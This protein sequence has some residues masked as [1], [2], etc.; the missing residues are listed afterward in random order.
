MK[1]E[2]LREGNIVQYNGKIARLGKDFLQNI[3]LNSVRPVVITE[4]L[5]PYIGGVEWNYYPT[6]KFDVFSALIEGIAIRVI[7][8]KGNDLTSINIYK[9][10]SKIKWAA[11]SKEIPLHF[12]Q[13]KYFD[14][15]G[16]KLKI[17]L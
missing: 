8:D 12:F 2:E 17:N 11:K 7:I 4:K 13:N 14:Y 1:I 3:S 6:N 5:L 16:T 9:P 10:E 15:I